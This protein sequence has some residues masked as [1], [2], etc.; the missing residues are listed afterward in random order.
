MKERFST[1]ALDGAMRTA[2]TTHAN[3]AGAQTECF[4]YTFGDTVIDAAARASNA[5]VAYLNVA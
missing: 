1:S 5:I 3:Y 4:G 2:L